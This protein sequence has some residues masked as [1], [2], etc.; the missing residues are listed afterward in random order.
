V[1][2][3]QL[4]KRTEWRV[5]DVNSMSLP[6]IIGHGENWYLCDG[7][8]AALDTAGALIDGRQVSVHVA[9]EATPTGH[10]LTS[11]WHLEPLSTI[12]SLIF[13]NKYDIVDMCPSAPSVLWRCLLGGRKGI[14]PVEKTQWWDAGV[15]LG[16]GVDLHMAQ[17]I[18]LTLI[19]SC[20]RKYRLVLVLPFWYQLTR[21][22]PDKIQRAVKYWRQ[23]DACKCAGQLNCNLLRMLGTQQQS[24]IGT[25]KSLDL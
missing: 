6:T 8:T 25:I 11:R 22:V 13:N 3:K 23:K 14:R 5:L 24:L 15:C 20:S 9:G 1:L 2:C 18:P 7:A 10:L 4:N 12:L 21:R 19:V 17:L 16:Q